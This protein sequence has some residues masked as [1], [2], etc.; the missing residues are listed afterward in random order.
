MIHSKLTI[1][2]RPWLRRLF[3]IASAISL[4]LCLATLVLWTRSYSSEDALKFRRW[5]VSSLRGA[6][7]FCW[8]DGLNVEPAFETKAVTSFRGIIGQLIDLSDIGYMKDHSFIY[9]CGFAVATF[10]RN[11]VYHIFAC[12]LWIPAILFAIAP[13]YWFFAPHRRRVKRAKL[14]LC[15]TCGYDLRATPDRCPE[16]GETISDQRGLN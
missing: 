7:A 4:L 15:P 2:R 12:P 6:I 9:G 14:G 3:T 11:T 10:N 5:Q 13:T 1:F 16:C 8:G